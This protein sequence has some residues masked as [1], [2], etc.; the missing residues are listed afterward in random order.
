[1]KTSLNSIINK[2]IKSSIKSFI[3]NEYVFRDNQ[4]AKTM[5][6]FIE[7]IIDLKNYFDFDC[8]MIYENRKIFHDKILYLIIK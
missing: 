2:I 6:N 8:S 7:K 3:K 5:I 4:Y 1:M